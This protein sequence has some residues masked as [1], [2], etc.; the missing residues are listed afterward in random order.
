MMDELLIM[1]Q[2]LTMLEEGRDAA[3]ANWRKSGSDHDRLDHDIA[4]KRWAM[5]EVA[6]GR[7]L[8]EGIESGK[9]K[10]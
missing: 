1:R 2:T 10:P 9:V 7:K 3:L 6:Y 8:Q 5:A 4:L